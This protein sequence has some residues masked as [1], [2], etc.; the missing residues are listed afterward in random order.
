[1]DDLPYKDEKVGC[2]CFRVSYDEIMR[3]IKE[4]NPKDATDIMKVCRAGRGCGM[5]IPYI[6]YY[7]RKESQK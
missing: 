3:N 1:M 4:H 6:D 2:V 7:I 5:C